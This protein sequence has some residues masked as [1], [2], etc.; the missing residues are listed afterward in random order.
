M[1]ICFSSTGASLDSTLDNRFGRC[2]YFVLFDS[3]SREVTAI[4][5]KGVNSPHGAG[6]AAA[7]QISN[8]NVDVIVTCNM[9]PNAMDI[10]N[11]SGSKIYEGKLDTLENNFK[12]LE[13]KDLEELKR[14][15]AKHFGLRN[16]G[17]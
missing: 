7:T 17:R 2:R 1:K 4:E 5:N 9:G 16:R 8:E 3:D 13:S 6:V 12:L 14:P 11:T 15:G 10:I